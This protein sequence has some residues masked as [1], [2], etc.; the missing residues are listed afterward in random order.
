MI[1]DCNGYEEHG[2]RPHSEGL[3]RITVNL[4]VERQAFEGSVHFDEDGRS[5][6][7]TYVALERDD[8]MRALLEVDRVIEA[9]GGGLTNDRSG[10]EDV[11]IAAHHEPLSRLSACLTCRR[12]GAAAD[13]E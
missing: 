10:N 11:S 13:E 5:D 3:L 1:V 8:G 7:L 2:V 4:E 12:A 6:V 9:G